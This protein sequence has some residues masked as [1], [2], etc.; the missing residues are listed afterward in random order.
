MTSFAQHPDTATPSTPHFVVQ[1]PHNQRYVPAQ[2]DHQPISSHQQFAPQ[3]QPYPVQTQ[4]YQQPRFAYQPEQQPATIHASQRPAYPAVPSYGPSPGGSDHG[5]QLRPVLDQRYSQSS[6]R[7]ARTHRS[8]RSADSDR[9][10]D[11]TKSYKSSRSHRSHRSHH[12]TKDESKDRRK[13]RDLDARPTMGD[14]VMLVV[15]HFRDMLS[16]DTR[17]RR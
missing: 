7:S 16:S 6:F 2:Y 10:H 1:D 17:S 5:Q 12:S 9:S 3:T 8:T 13:K 4:H 11:S 15:N 14:S